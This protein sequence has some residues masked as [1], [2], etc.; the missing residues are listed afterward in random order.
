V[1]DRLKRKQSYGNMGVSSSKSR[2]SKR[3]NKKQQHHQQHEYSF[4][5]FNTLSEELMLE[6]LSYVAYGPFEFELEEE[7]KQENNSDKNERNGNSKN[8]NQTIFQSTLT[9]NLPLVSR[10]FRK[11]CFQDNLWIPSLQRLLMNNP[12]K[13]KYAL[14]SFV[15]TGDSTSR[16]QWSMFYNPI[17]DRNEYVLDAKVK[18][19]DTLNRTQMIDLIMEIYKS[20]VVL[21]RDEDELETN[22]VENG[23]N[24]IISSELYC[25]SREFYL[26]MIINFIHI[27]VPIFH[28]RY[29]AL[30]EGMTISL[31]LFEPRYRYLINEIMNGRKSSDF[32]G[33]QLARPRPKFI[34]ANQRRLARG[35]SAFLVE[36]CRCK[37]LEAGRFLLKISISKKVILLDVKERVHLENGLHDAHI[38]RFH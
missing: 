13:W 30:R 15:N 27:S 5:Q 9:H 31:R 34:F 20:T 14:A 21:P 26:T 33:R 12:N 17:V 37:I 28:M 6:I 32:R 19:I 1:D 8:L 38:K 10:Q 35:T 24:D 25:R 11:L 4:P 18:K 22:D 3:H 7:E 36:V 16:P 2:P 23:N 29:E